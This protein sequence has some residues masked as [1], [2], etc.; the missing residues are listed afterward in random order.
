MDILLLIVIILVILWF[1]G[2]RTSWGRTHFSD[3][4]LVHI[5]LVIAVIILAI[6]LLRSV[7]HLF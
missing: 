6:W 1:T 7:L 3:Q 2:W 5:I 4:K